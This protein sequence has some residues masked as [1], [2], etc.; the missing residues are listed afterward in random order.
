MGALDLSLVATL[1]RSGKV[2]CGERACSPLAAT[3]EVHWLAQCCR[4]ASD[5]RLR[6]FILAVAHRVIYHGARVIPE[7][8]L[9][10]GA[11]RVDVPGFVGHQGRVDLLGLILLGKRF[12][13]IDGNRTHIAGA[14]IPSLNR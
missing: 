10:T 11:A 13:V 3:S 6:P 5:T 7:A 2:E 9:A 8:Y 12:G 1:W 14:T 4:V